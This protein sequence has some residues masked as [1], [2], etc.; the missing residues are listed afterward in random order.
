MLLQFSRL[1]DGGSSQVP[2]TQGRAL[3]KSRR[4]LEGPPATSLADIAGR[5]SVGLQNTA[6]ELLPIKAKSSKTPQNL[7]PE[8]DKLMLSQAP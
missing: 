2:E 3:I 1:G 5:G 6:R 7:D 8:R 4:S